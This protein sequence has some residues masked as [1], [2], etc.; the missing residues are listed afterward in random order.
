[1]TQE[2]RFDGKTAVVTGAGGNPSLGRA[3][4]LLLG[5][6]GANVVVNDIGADPESKNYK[7][8]ASAETVAAEIR[9]AGGKAVADTNSVATEA[10]AAAL[11]RTA[12]DT[13]GSIDIIVNNAAISAMA[14]FDEITSRDIVRHI[15][16]NV[17]GPIWVC[18]AAWPYMKKSRYGRIVNIGSGAMGGLDHFTAYGT[19]KGAVFSLTRCLAIEGRGF[20]IKVNA[21][22]PAAHTRMLEA[23]QEDD[24]ILLVQA[25]QH[26]PAEL[27][28]PAVAL[29]CHEK[30]PVTGE[31]IMAAGGRVNRAYLSDTKGIFDPAL[32]MESLLEKWEGVVDPTDAVITPLGETDVKTW[33]V[34]PYAG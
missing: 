12:V 25:K 28:A 30:C 26:A 13:F 21:I 11:V 27:V 18:R 29:L 16:V 2:L 5:A 7:G 9:A 23:V 3:H 17:M 10:G 22:L 8:V 20:G 19:S 31:A 33:K 1:M 15:D 34:K 24:S 32:S 4:A 6:R 14:A